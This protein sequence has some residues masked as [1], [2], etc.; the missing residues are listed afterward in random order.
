MAQGNR[1]QQPTGPVATEIEAYREGGRW[2]NK[3]PSP[4]EF[5]AWFKDNVRIDEGLKAEHY[6]GGITIIPAEE[7]VK[8]AKGLTSSGE[9]IIGERKQMTYTPYPRVSA[10]VSY[11]WDLMD[12][13]ADDWHGVIEPVEI[14]RDESTGVLGQLNRSLPP[15]FFVVPIPVADSYTY[16]VCYSYRVR[17]YERPI[18]WV[19]REEPIAVQLGDRWQ[20]AHVK[21]RVIANLPIREGR[22][23]KQIPLLKRGYNNT[24]YADD[25]SLLRAE[26]GAQGRALAACGILVMAGGLSSAEDMLEGYGQ[27]TVAQSEPTQQLTLPVVEPPKPIATV[28]TEAEK[29]EDN[30][31]QLIRDARSILEELNEKHKEAYAEFGVWAAAQQP[32]LRNLDAIPDPRLRGVVKKLRVLLKTAEDVALAAAAQDAAEA[33]DVPPEEIQAPAEEPTPETP[34]ETEDA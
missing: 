4:E 21:R 1:Q 17:V 13:R 7:K 2:I 30:R 32:P 28:V 22:A 25:T 20:V 3:R 6:I 10:R 34:E 16:F 33:P 5:A 18:E 29:A 31:A 24:M 27:V 12:L 8:W 26:T 23:T 15:G 11:F 14:K 9:T 19:E